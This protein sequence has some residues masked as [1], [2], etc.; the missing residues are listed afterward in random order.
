ML[1]KPHPNDR[2]RK[3][4]LQKEYHEVT[5]RYFAS[6][7][8]V[9]VE[10]YQKGW[11]RYAVLDETQI[12]VND[13]EHAAK[14]LE[15]VRRHEYSSNKDFSYKTTRRKKS[16]TEY[17]EYRLG[18]LLRLPDDPRLHKFFFKTLVVLR[19]FPN[20]PRPNEYQ[21]RYIFA[22]PRWYRVVVEPNIITHELRYDP[23]LQS[24]YT[25]FW[26]KIRN[27]GEY[28]RLYSNHGDWY[29]YNKRRLQNKNSKDID[30]ELYD[31]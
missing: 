7:Y 25:R 17:R 29:D 3:Y 10:P 19:T 12:P 28:F 22:N 31:A 9:E 5:K 20:T 26:N 13:R 23:V 11:V 2:K 8:W 4:L 1:K 24:E 15:L 14:A 21:E 16:K 6:S 27:S 18:Y 30:M